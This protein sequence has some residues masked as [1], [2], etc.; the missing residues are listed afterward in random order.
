MSGPAHVRR[1][2]V[3]EGTGKGCAVTT[4]ALC[5]AATYHSR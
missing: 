2:L 1:P 4:L 3:G 5:A